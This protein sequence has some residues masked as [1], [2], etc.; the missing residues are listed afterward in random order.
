MVGRNCTL[1]RVKGGEMSRKTP[2]RGLGAGAPGHSKALLDK[3]P[4]VEVLVEE[5]PLHG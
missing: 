2:P 3:G 4:G 5:I 1:P